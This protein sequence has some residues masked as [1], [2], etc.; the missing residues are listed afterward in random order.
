LRSNVPILRSI[1]PAGTLFF[2][3]VGSERVSA[4]HTTDDG[5]EA[6]GESGDRVLDVLG[7]EVVIEEDFVTFPWRAGIVRAP[8]AFAAV[9]ALVFVLAALPGLDAEVGFV[10]QLSIIGI[11]SFNAHNIPAATALVPGAVTPVA[12]PVLGV[13][14][15]GRLLRGLFVV[16]QNH[17]APVAHF[18]DIAGGE[19]GTIG[20]VNFIEQQDTQVPALIY[21]L[22]PVAALVGA[23]YE[24]AATYWDR[25]A[26]DSPLEVTRFGIA[27]GVGYV[28]TLLAGTVLFTIETTSP[29]SLQVFIV[30]P[31]RYL[32]LVFGF[33]YPAVLGSLGAAVVY[34]RRDVLDDGSENVDDGAGEG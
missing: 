20:H 24:F 9:W 1:T 8:V 10:D 32:T 27:I 14:V 2:V 6:A 13:P 28:L 29:L 26:T 17:A 11:V 15:V 18:L 25:A 31:D 7:F 5:T 19:S 12:E 16:G 33:V 23:G 3:L 22:V 4:E 34:V 21:Y 30:L